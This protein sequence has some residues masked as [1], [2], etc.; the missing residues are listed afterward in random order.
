MDR[1]VFLKSLPV[2]G[3]AVTV[4]K[5]VAAEPPVDRMEAKFREFAEAA[6]DVD[7]TIRSFIVSRDIETGAIVS[8]EVRYHS[9]VPY[10]GPGVYVAKVEDDE[11]RPLY[12]AQRGELFRVSEARNG[13]AWG[14]SITCAPNRLRLDRKVSGEKGAVL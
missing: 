14:L 5:P 1:R 9:A 4:A 2:A 12:I 7:P 10:S 8:I 11:A 3:A 13:E 6:R